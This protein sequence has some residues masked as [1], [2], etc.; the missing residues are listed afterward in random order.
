[1]AFSIYAKL[2][3]RSCT[4]IHIFAPDND[5][6]TYAIAIQDRKFVEGSLREFT[7]VGVPYGVDDYDVR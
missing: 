1:M 5:A 2:N 3:G 6:S 4:I 7:D